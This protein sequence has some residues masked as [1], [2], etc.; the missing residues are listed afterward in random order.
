MISYCK[1]VIEVL[2]L[3]A[4]GIGDFCAYVHFWYNVYP[5]AQRAYAVEIPIPPVL[6]FRDPRVK[7]AYK[8]FGSN[9]DDI[10]MTVE[11]IMATEKS[12]IVDEGSSIYFVLEPIDMPISKLMVNW[13]EG[14]AY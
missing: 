1:T 4:N 9:V 14:W 7:K 8:V 12:R 5:A 11:L 6:R 13:M 10:L 2:N 3:L